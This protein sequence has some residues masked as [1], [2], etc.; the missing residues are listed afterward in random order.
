MN[1]PEPDAFQKHTIKK[2]KL[3]GFFR[4]NPKYKKWAAGFLDYIQQVDLGGESYKSIISIARKFLKKSDL[5]FSYA[6]Q[7]QSDIAQGSGQDLDSKTFNEICGASASY[8]LW[9]SS[10]MK[11][12]TS[13]PSNQSKKEKQNVRRT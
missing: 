1:V 6:N 8:L 10:R 12:K 3:E 9:D 11:Q 5:L 7:I 4:N 13:N 2:F